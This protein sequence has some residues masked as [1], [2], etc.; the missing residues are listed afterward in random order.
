VDAPSPS[1]IFLFGDF[2][3][4]RRG[5]GLFRRAYGDACVPVN[6]GSRALDVLWALIER[7]GDLVSKD[8][9]MALSGQTPSS[10]KPILRS[11][12]RRSAAPLARVLRTRGGFRPYLGAVTVLSAL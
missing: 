10:R 1:D 4:D 8:E 11:R 2:R 9:I 7:H 6:L 5:G 12:Y 3:L